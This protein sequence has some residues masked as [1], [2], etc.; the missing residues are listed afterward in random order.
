MKFLFLNLPSNFL[1]EKLSFFVIFQ[2][3]LDNRS[4]PKN[5][6]SGS[7]KKCGSI[8]NAAPP[9]PAPQLVMNYTVN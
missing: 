6:G 2:M 4:R 7:S 8:K 1:Y 9:A 3:I 5:L